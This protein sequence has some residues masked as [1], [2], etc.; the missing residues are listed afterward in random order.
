[1]SGGRSGRGEVTL[2]PEMAPTS[3]YGHPV[4]KRPVWQ[5]EIGVY[6]F[7]GGL[8]GASAMLAAAARAQ[9]NDVLARRALYTGL[10]AVSASPVL[11]IKDLGVPRRFYN[12]LRVVKV[13]SP[14]SVGS[15]LLSASGAATG[16]AAACDLLGILPR[17]QRTAET[18]AALLG[19]PLATY[20]AALLADTAVPVWH[21]A[22]TELPFLFA[23]SSLAS[24]GAAAVVLTPPRHAALARTV[25]LTGA[26]TE[27]AAVQVMERQLGELGEVYH[28]GVPHT[29]ARAAKALSAAGAA[30]IAV[31]GRRRLPAAA[32]GLALLAGAACERWSIFTAGT[33]SALDPRYTVGPQRRR[34][35][36]QRRRQ[37]LGA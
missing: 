33:A 8:A 2:V 18:G 5:P 12:M 30:T 31:A 25:A 27:L 36:E 29:S 16:V 4:I 26:A 24:A 10:A 11:L 28:E 6:L 21:E 32:G 9:G 22:R 35:R 34:L 19:P 14:M 1:M 3:Y 20:T 17:L 37:H 7:S 13:T 23:G 15:W